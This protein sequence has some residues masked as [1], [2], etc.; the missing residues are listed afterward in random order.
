VLSLSPPSLPP[1][2]AGL[3][4]RARVAFTAPTYQRFVL[5]CVAAI[6]AVRRRTVSRLLWAARWLRSPSPVPAADGGEGAHD[7]G[8][9][10]VDLGHSSSYHRV[11]SAAR[12]RP[13]VVARVLAALALQRVPEGEPVVLCGDDTV[14]EHRG[15]R[16]FGKACHRDAVRSTTSRVALVWGHKW[17]TL[18]VNVSLPPCSRAWALPLLAALY[19]PPPADADADAEAQAKG[20]GIDIGKD[21]GK[22][23][24]KGKKKKAPSRSRVLDLRRRDPATGKFPPRDKTP[25]LLMRQMLA[26]MIHWFPERRFIL[27]GDWGFGSHELALFC[28]RHRR[29]VALVA[30]FRGDATLYALYMPRPLPPK[31]K[32]RTKPAKA[33]VEDKD[34]D[35]DKDKAPPPRPRWLCR[36]G[37][38]LPRPMD[39]VNEAVATCRRRSRVRWYGGRLRDVELLSGCGGWYR[40]RGGGRAAVVP[41]RWVWCRERVQGEQAYFYTTDVSLRPERIVALYAARWAIE[42]TFEEARAHLGFQTTRQWCP[43][44][45]RRTVPCLLGL[46]TAVALTFADLAAA[47]RRAGR[48]VKV[49]TTPCYAKA[50]PTFGDAIAAVRVMLW[51][52]VIL[53]HTPHGELVTKLPASLREL[54]LDQLTAVT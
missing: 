23:K 35:K 37:R 17:V 40:G 43:N 12:W 18:A 54:L 31:G 52:Q 19:V 53:P 25:A 48:A 45:V 7:D 47:A 29:H 2:A 14:A 1:S 21:K 15:P 34:K 10:E 24:G 16:V 38:R 51:E 32:P 3:L 26:V 6:I 9:T 33:K 36:K 11:F 49:H 41:V 20:N 39:A 5:L 44:A 4:E 42:V 27:L 50:D 22:K 13:L 46:F 30:R 28:H 8:G